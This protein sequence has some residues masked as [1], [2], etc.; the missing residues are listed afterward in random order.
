MDVQ[1][2][3]IKLIQKHIG[4]QYLF[5]SIDLKIDNQISIYDCALLKTS[6]GLIRVYGPKGT[7]KK[8]VVTWSIDGELGKD[9]LELAIDAYEVLSG[10]DLEAAA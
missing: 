8:S 10:E 4:N 9:I 6:T 7:G 3:S 5:A 1:V 2:N